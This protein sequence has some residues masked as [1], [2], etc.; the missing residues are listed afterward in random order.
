V[1]RAPAELPRKP[2]FASTA[3]GELIDVDAPSALR[4]VEALGDG[5]LE[6]PWNEKG[7]AVMKTAA[8]T[9]T[10]AARKAVIAQRARLRDGPA[11][12]SLLWPKPVVSSSVHRGGTGGVR[13][14]AKPTGTSGGGAHPGV[15]TG[16]G[17]GACGSG[18][19]RWA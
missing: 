1:G 2:G 11:P 9:A 15:D 6:E 10:I 19:A 8:Q 7:S 4:C 13:A 18:G 5:E 14:T 16:A 12:R 17:G 3:V